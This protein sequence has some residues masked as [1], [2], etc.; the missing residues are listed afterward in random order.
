MPCTHGLTPRNWRR[1]HLA[2]RCRQR[3]PT[4]ITK[5]ALWHLDLSRRGW[6]REDVFHP[7]RWVRLSAMSVGGSLSG[8]SP[9]PGPTATRPVFR[10]HA[11]PARAHD[12]M[13]S[14]LIPPPS[15][16]LSTTHKSQSH[17]SLATPG[18]GATGWS[19]S[20]DATDGASHW[21]AGIPR[22]IGYALCVNP[23]LAPS[24]RFPQFEWFSVHPSNSPRPGLGYTMSRTD[25]RTVYLCYYNNNNK[26]RAGGR[27][28]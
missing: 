2:P 4:L 9:G 27:R 17:A 6:G 8:A 26:Q 24:L 25:T 22:W 5:S 14:G 28:A 13:A 11:S 16:V 23:H 21:L 15:Q 3:Q 19:D 12:D 18:K 7:S 20:L 10:G 1:G